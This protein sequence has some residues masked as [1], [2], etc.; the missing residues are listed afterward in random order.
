MKRSIFFFF[1]HINNLLTANDEYTP[2]TFSTTFFSNFFL[3]FVYYYVLKNKTRLLYRVLLKDLNNFYLLFFFFNI[4]NFFLKK[5]I[6][7]FFIYIFHFKK[8]SFFEYE[9]SL[10]NLSNYILFYFSTNKI[11]LS[12]YSF[13]DVYILH[14][15]NIKNQ[16]K[17]DNFTQINNNKFENIKTLNFY[18]L[19]NCYLKK[20]KSNIKF[21][22]NRNESV[23]NLFISFN[24]FYEDDDSFF[25]Y[26]YF[27]Q[28]WYLFF[29]KIY[30]YNLKKKS[31]TFFFKNFLSIVFT[32]LKKLKNLS[33]INFFLFFNTY[34]NV[35]FNYNFN[36]F[37]KI[38]YICSSKKLLT[39]T[40]YMQF[41]F[42]KKYINS[43]LFSL[44]VT[45]SILTLRKCILFF[46]IFY[47]Y[48]PFIKSAKL[49]ND[50][51]YFKLQDQVSLSNTYKLI[52]MWQVQ[53]LNF[54]Y[55]RC[56]K[57]ILYLR[58][59]NNKYFRSFYPIAGIRILCSGTFY[60]GR[61]K[62]KKYYHLWVADVFLTGKMNLN[63]FNSSIDYYHSDIALK[64]A[65][66]GI[67]VWIL[68][69]DYSQFNLW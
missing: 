20:K 37:N 7:F 51:V 67:K 52:Q 43:L 47:K 31:S 39:F 1:S 5:K 22:F 30:I 48:K 14:N 64:H 61:R 54:F 34:K 26:W 23:A 8:N 10:I 18:H 33:T 45:I 46:N 16:F 13:K 65:T 69:Y 55:Y 60:K 29:N 49:V 28:I 24:S 17:T 42:L 56:K 21:F 11:K 58:N 6:N 53:N 62:L 59:I 25:L 38:K 57:K 35:Q 4:Y 12:F 50:Y 41:V 63:S 19:I 32:L 36:I 68:L 40:H 44:E 3:D 9:Y 27:K 2:F 15:T 66:L